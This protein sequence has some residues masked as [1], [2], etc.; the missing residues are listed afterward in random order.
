[1]AGTTLR[2][3]EASLERAWIFAALALAAVASLAGVMGP[4]RTVSAVVVIVGIVVVA[5]RPQWGVAVIL[6]F[7]MV[8]YG[9]RRAEREGIAGVINAL[10]PAG[11]GLFTL[12][13]VLGM[14]L[15]LVLVYRV[16]RDGDWSFVHSRQVRLIG[17]ITLVLI[18]SN[19]LNGVDYREQAEL[20]LRIKGQDPMRLM[21]SR[22]LFLLL[23]AAFVRAPGISA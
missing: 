16:Y 7:L 14:Y 9:T 12:N 4:E 21:V 3:G 2:R 17:L 23:F 11:E 10:I 6:T 1:M 5:A 20:G 8:Q 15:A 22:G 19:Q 18:V 13:N